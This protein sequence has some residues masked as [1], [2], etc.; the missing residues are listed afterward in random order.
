MMV[1]EGSGKTVDRWLGVFILQALGPEMGSGPGS[2][3][4]QE[5]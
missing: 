4:V 1:K 3:L 5:Q 2:F